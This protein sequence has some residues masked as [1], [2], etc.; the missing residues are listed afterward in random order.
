MRENAICLQVWSKKINQQIHL[1]LGFR[2]RAMEK[3]VGWHG[4]GRH[5]N[6]VV[7]GDE[8]SRLVVAALRWAEAIGVNEAPK[9]GRCLS[10]IPNSCSIP[11]GGRGRCIIGDA[12][13]G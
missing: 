8:A 11:K 9:C 13:S 4:N 7:R 1:G 5:G 6:S 12:K 2:V 10:S 3:K